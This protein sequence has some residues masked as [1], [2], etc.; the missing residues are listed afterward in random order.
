MS[1]K[2]SW[3]KKNQ[4][5]A[6]SK[7]SINPTRPAAEEVVERT[8]NPPAKR[9]ETEKPADASKPA[10]ERARVVKNPRRNAQPYYDDQPPVGRIEQIFTGQPQPREPVVVLRQMSNKEVERMRRREARRRRDGQFPPF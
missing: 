10:S 6:V 4:D 3:R 1:R 9:I 7:V 5:A 2:V 8:T